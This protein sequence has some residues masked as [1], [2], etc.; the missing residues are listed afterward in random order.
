MSDE[1]IKRIKLVCHKCGE[2]KFVVTI[3][4]EWVDLTCCNCEYEVMVERQKQ[5]AALRDSV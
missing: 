5:L 1:P 4:E 2:N 3:T